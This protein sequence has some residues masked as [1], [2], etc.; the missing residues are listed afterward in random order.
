MEIALF[1]GKCSRKIENSMEEDIKNN[2][3]NQTL[4][5]III[6]ELRAN[7]IDDAND[8]ISNDPLLD[9]V[10]CEKGHN[11]S[12]LCFVQGDISHCECRRGFELDK[13][14]N[15]SCRKVGNCENGFEKNDSEECEDIDECESDICKP[16]ENCINTEG[17]FR[18]ERK[19][20]SVGYR[21]NLQNGDCEDVDECRHKPCSSNM[22]C[23]NTPGSFSCECEYGYR[24][25]SNHPRKCRDID[26]CEEHPMLCDHKCYNTFGTYRCSCNRGY[27]LQHDNRT[28]RDIDECKTYGKKMCQGICK[29]TVGDYRCSC[30][31]GLKLD[32]ERFCKGNAKKSNFPDHA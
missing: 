26:E 16:Y 22:V 24:Y 8:N 6:R 3:C 18:C 9:N 21:L 28:C 20:C 29:N 10:P 23:I 12:Q 4:N 13:S 19:R 15:R 30:Q 11:C 17:S 25:D 31:K 32:R 14:D 5:G 1:D 27:A 7:E 2:C